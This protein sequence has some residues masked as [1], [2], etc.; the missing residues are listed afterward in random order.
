M[1]MKALFISTALFLCFPKNS[2]AD[3]VEPGW[4]NIGGGFGYCIKPGNMI[5]SLS[6]LELEIGKTETGASQHTTCTHG[7][8]IIKKKNT[9]YKAA[10]N[11]TTIGANG[12]TRVENKIITWRLIGPTQFYVSITGQ[13][14]TR[15]EF[16]K[17]KCKV[18]KYPLI[19]IQLNPGLPL[20][21]WQQKLL[22]KHDANSW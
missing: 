12:Q 19:E 2:L 18:S 1:H 4:W 16:T 14:L 9:T 21:L 6:V 3:V 7:K 13:G 15:Y 5:P 11:C 20:P 10:L 22:L 17:K 8:W